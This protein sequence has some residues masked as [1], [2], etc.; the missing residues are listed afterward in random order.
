MGARVKE[1]VFEADVPARDKPRYEGHVSGRLTICTER[2]RVDG[3]F[4]GEHLE[5]E[6]DADAF[7]VHQLFISRVKEVRSSR[8]SYTR[9]D[10]PV[11]KQLPDPD[12]NYN[13]DLSYN[14]LGNPDRCNIPAA[15]FREGGRYA[16]FK[17]DTANRGE[18][19]GI[20]IENITDKVQ[21]FR[22]VLRG[23]AA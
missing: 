17:M 8:T 10:L 22:A 12:K 7:L 2:A 19:L 11:R 20:E 3:L 9:D 5:I 4:R 18:S 16:R 15:E 1:Y 23:K 6:G 21:H 13:D 14:P